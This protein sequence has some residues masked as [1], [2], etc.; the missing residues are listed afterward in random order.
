MT[1]GELVATVKVRKSGG[2]PD[3]M[4]NIKFDNRVIQKAIDLALQEYLSSE[5]SI[6]DQYV[7]TFYPFVLWDDNGFAYCN[8]PVSMLAL[9]NNVALRWVSGRNDV[10]TSWDIIDNVSYQVLGNMEWLSASEKQICYIEGNRLIFP[11]I[12]KYQ[13]PFCIKIKIFCGTNGYTMSEEFPIPNSI[14][15]TDTICR[16]LEELRITNIKPNVGDPN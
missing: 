11:K 4:S 3:R 2:I 5:P 1:K 12:L 16:W 13:T 10:T 15:F 14:S 8:I 9:P 6:G 7:K